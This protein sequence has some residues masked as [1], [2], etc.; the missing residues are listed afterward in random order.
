LPTPRQQGTQFLRLSVGQGARRRPYG[1]SKM[2]QGAGIEDIRLGQLP[3]GFGNV[4]RL[5]RIDHDD[6]QARRRQRRYHGPLVASGRFAHNELRVNRLESRHEG[7]DPRLPI[8]DRPA[9]ARG[10]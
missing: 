3:R 2:R 10:P 7:G 5:A 1:I 4:T 6:R 8:G 9:F